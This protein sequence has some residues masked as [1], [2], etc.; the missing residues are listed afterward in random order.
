MRVLDTN[1]VSETMRAQPHAAVLAWLDAQDPSDLW[2]TAVVAAELMSGVARLPDARKQ[3]LAH[4]VAAMLEQDFAGQVL[5]FDL[6]AASVYADLVAQRER[7]GKPIGM[8]DAQIAATCL[9]H[10][11]TWS[12][13]TSRTSRT[14]A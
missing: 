3:Q 6:A 8:A 7:S 14:W 4:G 1:V 5:P 10:Q 9:V 11:A 13:A 2:L 12:R